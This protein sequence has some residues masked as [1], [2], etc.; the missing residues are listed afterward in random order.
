M[1]KRYAVQVLQLRPS[2]QQT[3]CNSFCI[4][5][6]ETI[7]LKSGLKWMKLDLYYY[8]SDCKHNLVA[9]T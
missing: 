5:F 9:L 8:I 3:F 7:N 2:N 4:F 1:N 6:L